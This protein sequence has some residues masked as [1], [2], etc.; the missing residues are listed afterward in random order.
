MLHLKQ[1]VLTVLQTRAFIY[2]SQ[3][4]FPGLAVIWHIFLLHVTEQVHSYLNILFELLKEHLFVIF[5][6]VNL[7]A[8]I[9]KIIV[10]ER[11]QLF[12]LK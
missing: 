4:W 1:S 2:E 5:I 6:N 9:N 7:L 12:G 10:F 11:R 8:I 3:V